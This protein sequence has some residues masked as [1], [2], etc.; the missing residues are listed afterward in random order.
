M[1]ATL[2]PERFRVFCNQDA[3]SAFNKGKNIVLLSLVESWVLRGLG[4][5][6][7]TYAIPMEKSL[8]ELLTAVEQT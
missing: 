6:D 7:N 8:E 4:S 3:T 1:E 2:V 5:L